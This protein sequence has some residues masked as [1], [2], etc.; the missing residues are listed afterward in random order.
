M[1]E[2]DVAV[3]HAEPADDAGPLTRATAAARL[4]AAERHVR[5]LL[6]VGATR[7]RDPRWPTGRTA[8][9]GAGCATWSPSSG[10]VA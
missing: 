6:D 4:D 5:G 7:A 1:T 3:L 2:V 10:M 9:R 8:V